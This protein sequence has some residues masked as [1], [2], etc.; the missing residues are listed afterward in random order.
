MLCILADRRGRIGLSCKFVLKWWEWEKADNGGS[1]SKG[2]FDTLLTH[3][4]ASG[5]NFVACKKG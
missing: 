1:N 3:T 4:G 2:L 5:N